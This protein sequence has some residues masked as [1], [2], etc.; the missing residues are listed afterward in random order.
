VIELTPG[1]VDLTAAAPTKEVL[2]KINPDQQAGLIVA[3]PMNAQSQPWA[4]LETLE[5]TPCSLCVVGVGGTRFRVRLDPT[6]LP[7]GTTYGVINLSSQNIVSNG[8][9]VT[10]GG[11]STTGVY[12]TPAA[13][14]FTQADVGP[15]TVT[16]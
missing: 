9:N 3:G 13:L 16:L 10:I 1:T 11:S 6:K 7:A 5:G 12:P 4:T 14:G 2:I 8:I 15:K